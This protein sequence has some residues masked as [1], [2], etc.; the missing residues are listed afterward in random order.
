MMKLSSQVLINILK[1]FTSI[2]LCLFAL[3]CS[4]LQ[5]ISQDPEYAVVPVPAMEKYS[6]PLDGAIYSAY[7]PIRIFEDTKARRVGDILT[8]T[9]AEQT[10]ANTKSSTTTA[11]DDALSLSAGTIF[12][13][14]VTYEGDTILQAASD[15]SRSFSGSGDSSQSNSLSGEITVT[16]TQVLANGN[17]VVAGEKIISINQGAEYVRVSG[18]IRPE[19]VNGNNTVVS[20][21]VAN[22]KISYGGGGALAEVNTK[23]WLSRFFSSEWWPF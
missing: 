16:V 17:L 13:R 6:K 2:V 21:K 12:G 1:T 18:I 14:P 19:D 11:K 22:A 7:R 15:A 4:Y 3:G 20:S 8:I 10:D 23:G 9:L 5:P